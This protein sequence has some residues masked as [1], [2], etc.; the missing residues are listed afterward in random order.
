MEA[1]E[2]LALDVDDDF[3]LTEEQREHTKQAPPQIEYDHPT[4]A[5]I[6]LLIYKHGILIDVQV[7]SWP[8]ESR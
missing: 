4:T 1:Y 8:S 2:E 3:N 6:S 7:V 5:L